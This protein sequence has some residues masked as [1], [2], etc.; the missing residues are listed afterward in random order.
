MQNLK[1]KLGIFVLS[2]VAT[3]SACGHL[4]KPRLTYRLVLADG[5]TGWVR[6]DFGVD[7]APPVFK[8]NKSH[9][10]AEIKIG[11]DGRAKTSEAM[12]VLSPKTEYEFFYDTGAGLKPIPEELINHDL[13]AGGITAMAQ[14]YDQ[15]IKPL[16]WYFFVGP[17]SYRM[18]HPNSEFLKSDASLP[19]PGPNPA[20]NTR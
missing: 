20:V 18:Q 11:P 4:S 15:P 17:K 19:V 12:V 5:Y 10:I 6:V 8:W 14:D 16:S 1:V 3:V 13:E 7:S 2:V 9:Q